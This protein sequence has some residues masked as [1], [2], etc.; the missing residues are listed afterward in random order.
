VSAE[1]AEGLGLK[2][3]RG[4]LVASV[5]PD[6]PAAKAGLKAGD[7]VLAANGKPLADAKTL[8]RVVGD[9]RPG[10]S[11]TLEVSREQK[12]RDLE[13]RIGTPP[14]DEGVAAAAESAGGAAATPRLGLALSPLTPE[15]RERFGLAQGK[16]G[17]VVVRVERDSPAAKAGIRA[18]SLISMVGQRPVSAPEDVAREVAAAAA[19]KRPTVLLLVEVDGE[20]SF[21]PVRFAA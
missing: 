15:A 4:T 6:S 19:E 7:I 18:G 1:V 2:E 5:V 17:V 20:K 12:T 11:L 3:E 8:A 16:E 10:T 14:G 9:S 13:V 21:V